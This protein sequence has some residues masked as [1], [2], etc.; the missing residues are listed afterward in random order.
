MISMYS[1]FVAVEFDAVI[2]SLFILISASINSSADILPLIMREG[3]S[4]A[5]GCTTNTS[6][7]SAAL[8]SALNITLSEPGSR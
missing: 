7:A 2:M 1:S 6:W 8:P 5:N 3:A 4:T